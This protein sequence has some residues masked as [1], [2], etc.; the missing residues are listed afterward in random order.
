[1]TLQIVSGRTPINIGVI[2]N[3]QSAPITETLTRNCIDNHARTV[4]I[5]KGW[6]GSFEIA[7]RDSALD[8]FFAAREHNSY[9]GYLQ[10]FATITETIAETDGS[11]TQ[12]RY[13]DVALKL[14]D[15]GTWRPDA[16]TTQ[17]VSFIAWR[18]IDP[19]QPNDASAFGPHGIRPP[20]GGGVDPEE[21]TPIFWR[22]HMN[23]QARQA[24]ADDGSH[25]GTGSAGR[26]PADRAEYVRRPAGAKSRRID[27]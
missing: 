8:K 22:S 14:E 10:A 16:A 26:R 5:P 6:R 27:G 15:A 23:K 11:I 3:F 1:V 19:T 21:T 9:K 7:R 13:V 20:G 24:R 2:T 17:R 12:F 25:A 18:R 4:E